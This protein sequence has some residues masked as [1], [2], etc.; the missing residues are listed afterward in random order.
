MRR[1]SST[2]RLL[3]ASL[4]SRMRSSSASA[5][6]FPD[7]DRQLRSQARSPGFLERN[8]CTCQG[9]Q[10]TQDRYDARTTGAVY[11]VPAPCGSNVMIALIANGASVAAALDDGRIPGPRAP[12]RGSFHDRPRLSSGRPVARARGVACSL[13]R[14]ERA[15]L[16][17]QRFSDRTRSANASVIRVILPQ[18]LRTLAGFADKARV[19]VAPRSRRARSSMCSKRVTRCCAERSA[20]AARTYVDRSCTTSPANAISRTSRR[21]RRCRMRLRSARS[22]C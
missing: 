19:D 20:T 3:W 2:S 17:K 9:L 5:R 6:R 14:G 8:F 12:V 15:D 18:H 21:M 11:F 22:R 13:H 16:R 7:A 4:T 10:T 1:C